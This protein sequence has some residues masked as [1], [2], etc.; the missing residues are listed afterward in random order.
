MKIRNGFVSNSSSASFSCEVCHRIWDDDHSPVIDAGLCTTCEREYTFCNCCE[1]MFEKDVLFT[2]DM[3]TIMRGRERESGEY[4][5][6]GDTWVEWNT[7]MT[8]IECLSKNPE[9]VRAMVRRDDFGKLCKKLCDPD[10]EPNE[11][12]RQVAAAILAEGL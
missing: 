7:E 11:A 1:M 12:E 4:I 9:L 10:Y 3:R 5:G 6:C 2:T 8:C